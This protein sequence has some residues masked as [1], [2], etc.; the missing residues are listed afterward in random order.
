MDRL[1]TGEGDSS[2]LHSGFFLGARQ[3]VYAVA[4][5][6]PV[7]QVVGKAG[8]VRG[9][10]SDAGELVPGV[11]GG[12]FGELAWTPPHT[13]ADGSLILTASSSVSWDGGRVGTVGTDV[14]LDFLEDFLGQFPDAEGDVLVT[15]ED[16]MVVG[17]RGSASSGLQPLTEL[18]PGLTVPAGLLSDAWGAP[19][20]LATLSGLG[21]RV[22]QVVR[23]GDAVSPYLLSPGYFATRAGDL[24]RAAG[25]AA[26]ADP[27]GVHL[28]VVGLVVRRAAALLEGRR[29]C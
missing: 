10:L 12:D 13:T 4:P 8:S 3:D 21:E 9:F 7:R 25:A 28:R 1:G 29:G 18:V 2:F 20:R 15:D 5:W 6:A 11:R 27:I 17:R 24:A 16:G 26:V 19:A 14:R 22:E 23:A